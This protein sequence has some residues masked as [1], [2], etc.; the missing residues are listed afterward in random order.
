MDFLKQCAI[1]L[2]CITCA[3]ALFTLSPITQT[4]AIGL[5]TI[6]V[7]ENVSD[8]HARVFLG[9]LA[10]LGVTWLS[11]VVAEAA[12]LLVAVELRKALHKWWKQIKL[13][14]F[15]RMQMAKS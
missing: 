12:A 10:F 11:L 14:R 5:A 9:I 3:I 7:T 8:P 2:A 1:W 4:A 6:P 15:A 13:A